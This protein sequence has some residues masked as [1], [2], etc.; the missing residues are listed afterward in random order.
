MKKWEI[1][2]A[3]TTAVNRIIKE[4]DLSPL[5]AHVMVARGYESVESLQVF[6]NNAE[7]FD[8]FLL[9]DMDKAVLAINEA[10]E[11]GDLIYVFGDYDCDGITASSIVYNY[12]L[13]MGANVE[14]FI[15]ERA[16]GYGLCEDLVDFFIDAEVKLVITVD[17]GISALAEAKALAEAGIKLVITDHHQPQDELPEAFAVVN[18]HR[19]DNGECF[20]DLAGVGV[21]FKLLAALDG[22]SYDMVLEQYGDIVALGTVADVVPL[23]S[24]N[25]VIVKKGLELLQNTENEGLLALMEEAG[26]NSEKL[27]ASTLGFG[28]APRINAS[29]RFGSPMTAF[30]CLT[31]EDGRAEELAQA[32]CKLNDERKYAEAGIFEEICEEISKNPEIANQRVIVVHGKDYH[33]GVIGIV[34]SKLVEAFGKPVILLS[35]EEFTNF[36]RGSARSIK[37]FNIFKCFD[38]CASLLEKYGG[39]ECAGGL[40]V[41][42]DRIEEFTQ[43]VQEY[44]KTKVDKMPRLT[45]TADKLL[46]PLDI[47]VDNVKDLKRLEPFGASN[48]EPLFAIQNAKILGIYPLKSGKHTKLDVSFGNTRLQALMFGTRADDFIYK[49]DDIVDIM[50]KLDINEFRGNSSVIVLVSDIRPSGIKQESFFA[51]FDSYE[52]F[53]RGEDLPK[54]YLQKGLPTR[55]ELVLCYKALK[56]HEYSGLTAEELAIICN[57]NAFKASVALDA[58]CEVR[59]AKRNETGLKVETVYYH[60]KADIMDSETIQKLQD[61]VD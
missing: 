34:A 45:L 13:N 11:S 9:K 61:L 33:H 41:A 16:M 46:S 58:F 23:V 40:T 7:L 4:T 50:G 29:G 12:L 10:I 14:C 5:T 28:L 25:R 27:T 37:G 31:D 15:P 1:L 36:A 38:A 57:I 21:A 8:P 6:F 20:K 52:A 42:L 51:A 53:K 43:A 49:K 35:D 32:L 48:P 30:E 26:I 22:G 19:K 60:G 55:D 39:H 54:A 3:D 44:A 18:P 17:N 24:E 56:A 59:L 2:S 47:S